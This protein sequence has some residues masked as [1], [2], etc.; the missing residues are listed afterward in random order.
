MNKIYNNLTIDNLIK[1]DW[2]NQFDEYQ[3]Q[4]I[5]EG[6]KNNLDVL[7]YAKPEFDES[8]MFEI[9]KGLENNI[10]VS[11]YAKPELSF[12]EMETIRE[13]LWEKST[14]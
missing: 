3:Q 13:K 8:Q 14:L 5:L 10:D 12:R 6:L 4:E 7:I 9:K 1:T 11:I 2:I